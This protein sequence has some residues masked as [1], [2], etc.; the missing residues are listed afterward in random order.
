MNNKENM[1]ELFTDELIDNNDSVRPNTWLT[2]FAR[3]VTSQYG[4]DG[5]I[6]KI[7]EVIGQS[8]KWCVE[9]GS[10]DGKR[11]SNTFN[12]IDKNG[13]SAILI[14]GDRKRFKDLEK[15]FEGNKKVILVNAFVG[16]EKENNLDVLLEATGIPVDFDLLSI[17]IDGNDYHVWQAVQDYK[18]KV[19]VIEFNPTIPKTVEFVQA[20]DIR[21]AQ[22]SSFLSI[23]KLAKS[24][25]YELVSTTKTNA[26]FVDSK[27][28]SLFG[29]RDNSV[30]TMMTDES[31]I[32]HIFCGYDGTVFIRGCGVMPWQTIAYKESRVQQLPKWARKI[33]GDHNILRKKLGRWFRRLRKKGIV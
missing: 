28:F 15:T 2:T 8:D 9:F 21:I 6:D 20:R 27:Y 18:P 12:L 24:K 3:N 5:I 7:L 1:A 29:I 4:E 19:V 17:D 10:W 32:T 31:L 22:G 33:T 23:N 16:F 14:E 11:C 26:F 25:G 13:Y 30:A